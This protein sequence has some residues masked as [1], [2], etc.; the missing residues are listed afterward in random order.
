[1]LSIYFN[2]FWI[3]LYFFVRDNARQ[4]VHYLE[5]MDEVEARGRVHTTFILPWGGL[6]KSTKSFKLSISS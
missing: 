4:G 1:M 5:L 3:L 6:P 2:I